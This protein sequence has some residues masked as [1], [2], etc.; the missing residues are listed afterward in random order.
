MDN[1]NLLSV[2]LAVIGLISIIL[3]VWAT[4]RK[5]SSDTAKAEAMSEIR[6]RAAADKERADLIEMIKA[7]TAQGSVWLDAFKTSEAAREKDYAT[8]KNL[9]EDGTLETINSRKEIVKGVDG[10][11]AKADEHHTGTTNILNEVQKEIAEIRRSVDAIPGK[12]AEILK[13]LDTVIGSVEMLRPKRVTTE[14]NA[15]AS[16]NGTLTEVPAS[17]S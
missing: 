12:H 17:S 16:T 14:I 2:I 5:N 1:T 7:S 10:L 11:S 3:G 4:T 9:I 15:V 8:T 6:A 13:R